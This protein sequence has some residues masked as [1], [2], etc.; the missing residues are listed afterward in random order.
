M[1]SSTD[2]VSPSSTPTFSLTNLDL[3]TAI[4]IHGDYLATAFSAT[5]KSFKSLIDASKVTDKS[6]WGEKLK[7]SVEAANTVLNDL[8]TLRIDYMTGRE[9]D[10]DVKILTEEDKDGVYSELARLTT[11][12]SIKP[13]EHIPTLLNK[14]CSTY[15]QY[16]S[17]GKEF[18]SERNILVSSFTSNNNQDPKS[19]LAKQSLLE[20][21]QMPS[22][23]DASP[24][25]ERRIVIDKAYVKSMPF[26]LKEKLPSAEEDRRNDESLAKLGDATGELLSLVYH[27]NYLHDKAGETAENLPWLP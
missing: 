21:N 12:I 16:R 11:L 2:S 5:Q 6:I 24:E 9:A 27:W 19:I 25:R 26:I 14:L 18:T 4:D 10:G 22:W 13:D 23:S 1:S 3:Q 17:Y 15:D 7:T 20:F 8:P